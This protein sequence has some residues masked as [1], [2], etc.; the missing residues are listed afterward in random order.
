M[1]FNFLACAVGGCPYLGHGGN[2]RF[3]HPNPV[4]LAEKMILQK[5]F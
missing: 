3:K 1:D 4:R 5:N 2:V